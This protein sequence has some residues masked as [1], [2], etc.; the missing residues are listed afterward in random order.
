M[1]RVEIEDG[2][3]DDE[4]VIDV[5]SV[6]GRVQPEE[7][8]GAHTAHDDVVGAGPLPDPGEDVAQLTV[9]GGGVR[10]VLGRR[11]DVNALAG[12]AEVDADDG[13]AEAGPVARQRH[14]QAAG[15]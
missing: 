11:I 13:E 14:V 3:V 4:D 5:S 10:K 8:T 2:R 7:R 1:I 9:P 15:A 6:H 12:M